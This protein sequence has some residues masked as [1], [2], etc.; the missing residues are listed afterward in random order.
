MEGRKEERKEDLYR[1]MGRPREIERER[2]RRRREGRGVLGE[3]E[4]VL[5]RYY[6]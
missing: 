5:L 4:P 6:T 2:E 3:A 1:E